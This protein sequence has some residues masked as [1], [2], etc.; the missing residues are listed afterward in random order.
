[1]SDVLTQKGADGSP[2]RHAFSEA[3]IAK[4]LDFVTNR[5]NLPA[6]EHRYLM[7]KALVTGINE[8]V[9]TGDFP[10][11]FGALIDRELLANYKA[12]VPDWQM[13]VKRGT[14][15]NFNTHEV[16]KIVGQDNLL[17]QVAEFGP[18]LETPSVTGNYTRQVFKFGRRFGISF[19]ALVNDSMGAFADISGRML[20]A[21]LRTESQL[22][23][24]SFVAAAGPSA[25]LYG[26]PIADVDGQNVTNVGVLPLTVG[27]LQTTLQLMALQ[28]DVNGERIAVR[29][30]HL[31]VPT[32][33]EMTARQILTSA[34]VQQ[35]DT[36]GGA[37]AVAPTFVPLP[38]TNVVP[39]LGIQLHVNSDLEIIDVSGTGDTTWYLFAEPSQGIAAGYDYLRGH[40]AP[41]IC[42]KASD[43]VSVGGGAMGIMSG[44]FNT[45]EIAYRVRV[46]GGPWHGDPRYTYAQVAP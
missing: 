1:M 46:I 25:A 20:Q 34:L 33:L 15:P 30:L 3:Q 31:V 11:L 26:A 16:H 2:V 6:F 45:D 44:D 27:N 10:T 4:G 38:T 21:A 40:E 18:Y 28:T 7:E 35:V 32:S 5:M 22:A 17:P 29:G 19:E 23:A 36:A 43:K 13:Y 12:V 42:M 9:G 41:E 24:Q 37:N 8:A 14:V 39:Q